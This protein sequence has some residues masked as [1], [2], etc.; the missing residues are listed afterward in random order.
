MSWNAMKI[1]LYALRLS[2]SEKTIHQSC[3]ALA[4]SAIVCSFSGISNRVQLQR[5]PP[6]TAIPPIVCS[7]SGISNSPVT[8]NQQFNQISNSANPPN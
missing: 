5:H 2:K 6:V 1:K 8:A 3:A 4:A 7:F